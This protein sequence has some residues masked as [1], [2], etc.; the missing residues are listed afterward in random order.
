MPTPPTEPKV[1]NACSVAL[2][3]S[4]SIVIKNGT[5]LVKKC[6]T[7]YNEMHRL[8]RQE[9][10]R[11]NPE[12]IRERDRNRYRRN[13]EAFMEKNRRG[14]YSRKYG[15]SI[16]QY[17]EMFAKQNFACALCKKPPKT[18]RLAV[19]HC[20]DTGRVRGLLCPSCNRAVGV[21][22][23]N[24]ASLLLVLDYVRGKQ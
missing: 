3:E 5:Y 6:R 24:E 19:D 8:K 18:N 12:K 21:L 13:R 14:E 16:P 1:C 22:G 7:C 2:V 9:E 23:D 15:I 4:N 20:H 10:R 17:N 11:N